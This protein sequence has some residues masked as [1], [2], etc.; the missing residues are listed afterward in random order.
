MPHYMKH[1]ELAILFTVF[2][3]GNLSSSVLGLQPNLV[4]DTEKKNNEDENKTLGCVIG[5]KYTYS[6][7]SGYIDRNLRRIISSFAAPESSADIPVDFF[8]LM[9]LLCQKIGAKFAISN[10]P[11]IEALRF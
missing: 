8:Y 9:L 4:K 6:S 2:A 7:N 5:T 10:E 11:L 1:W 3:S